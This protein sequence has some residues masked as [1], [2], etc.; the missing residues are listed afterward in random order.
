VRT[1]T[2][3][4]VRCI[5]IAAALA[6]ASWLVPAGARAAELGDTVWIPMVDPAKGAQETFDLN[7]LGLI[8]A[9]EGADADWRIFRGKFRDS[10]SRHDFFVT[11]GRPDLAKREASRR[12][13]HTA[14]LFGGYAAAGLGLVV[15]F[16]GLSKGGWD[17]PLLLAGG[18]I[19]GGVICAWVSDVFTGPDLNVDEAEA[20]V[21][22]YN[23]L[24]QS[25]L[26]RPTERDNRLQVLRSLRFTAW[27]VPG[28]G[29][30]GVA[31]RF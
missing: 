20:L 18:M 17:P 22:R 8:R 5:G 24:L 21:R 12:S 16:A 15:G 9:G 14:L 28:S 26:I 29:G 19:V 7:T 30:L 4:R 2:R 27:V 6:A 11:V 13:K 3:A 25:R 23:D 10:V 31:A 1:T